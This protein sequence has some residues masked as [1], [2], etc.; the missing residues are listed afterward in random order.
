MILPIVGIHIDM[1]D[2]KELKG[3]NFVSL[4]TNNPIAAAKL[5]ANSFILDSEIDNC[6]VW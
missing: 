4:V 3:I 6:Q 5:E 2:M 1:W